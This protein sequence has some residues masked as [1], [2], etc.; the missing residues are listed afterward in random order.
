MSDSCPWEETFEI[1]LSVYTLEAVLRAC[2]RFTDRSYVFLSRADRGS[3]NLVVLLRKKKASDE[4]PLAGEFYNE[5]VDQQ[6]R[7]RIAEETGPIRELI[8]AQAFAEGNLL[9]PR[10]ED[11]DY[12]EDP[13]GIAATSSA[14]A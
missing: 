12:H 6:L 11:G 2:Y 7:I 5:L 1:D 8:V 14:G 4:A 3:D 9:D 13:L 10:R